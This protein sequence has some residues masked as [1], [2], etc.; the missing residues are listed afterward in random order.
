[1]EGICFIS[2]DR[3]FLSGDK[4]LANCAIDKIFISLLNFE[5]RVIYNLFIQDCFN[6][7][8]SGIILSFSPSKKKKKKNR[9]KSNLQTSSEFQINAIKSP[10]LALLHV[11]ILV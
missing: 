5:K 4:I 3:T 1:M 8:Q 7:F 6:I 2:Q 10:P 11:I 9:Y